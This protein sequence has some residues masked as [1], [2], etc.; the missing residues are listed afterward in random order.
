M[1]EALDVIKHVR[2]GLVS[3]AVRLSRCAFSFQRGEETLHRGIVPAVAGSAHATGHAMVSQQPREMFTSGGAPSIG[4][5]QDGRRLAALPDRHHEWVRDQ[6]RGHR[7]MH[8]PA[9]DPS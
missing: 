3:R 8:R 4:V 7:R 1:R 5:M 6:L 2:V 9:D